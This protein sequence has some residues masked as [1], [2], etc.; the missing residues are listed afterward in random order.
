M[1]AK[2][3]NEE[4]EDFGLSAEQAKKLKKTDNP[5]HKL[6]QMVR[7]FMSEDKI[8]FDDMVRAFD[9]TKQEFLCNIICEYLRKTIDIDFQNIGE[10]Y[11]E[12]IYKAKYRA[13]DL[14]LQRSHSGYSYYVK[15]YKGRD[16]LPIAESTYSK[17]LHSLAKNIQ[18]MIKEYAK[19]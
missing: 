12:L 9:K 4:Y 11:G 19:V 16:R 2:S 17:S 1:R 5:F 3:V 8:Y 7:N 18:K 14:F 15:M 13:Y 6:E 10:E